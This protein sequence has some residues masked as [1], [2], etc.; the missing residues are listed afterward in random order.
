MPAGRVAVGL[1]RCSGQELADGEPF[2]GLVADWTGLEVA[3]EPLEWGC[4]VLDVAEFAY[5]LDGQGLPMIA[6]L[7][8]LRGCQSQGGEDV[9]R[10]QVWVPVGV[11]DVGAEP[12]DDEC[13][14]PEVVCRLAG[15]LPWAIAVHACVDLQGQLGPPLAVREVEVVIL[16]VGD[17]DFADAFQLLRVVLGA[18]S[19]CLELL[20]GP[21][22]DVADRPARG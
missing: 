22:A 18:I 5:S 4:C 7:T 21:S 20:E 14:Q 8:G 1:V 6:Q 11:L 12:I 13:P 2:S 16:S 9:G 10:D 15:L 3:E 19:P 17:G